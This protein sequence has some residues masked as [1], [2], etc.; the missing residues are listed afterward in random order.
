MFEDVLVVAV[1][2]AFYDCSAV[3]L[4]APSAPCTA[5][6]SSPWGCH[7]CPRSH[8]CITGG[9]CPTGEVTIY[10]QNASVGG[11]RGSQVCPRLGAVKGS[12]LVP[13]GVEVTLDLEAHN[14]NLLGVPLPRL[15]CVLEVGRGLVEVEASPGGPYRLQCGPHAYDFGASAPQ[16]RAPVYVTV[17]ERWHLD[18]PSGLHVMLTTA[19]APRGVPHL[20]ALPPLYI[21]IVCQVPPAEGG[22]S[23]PVEVAVGDQ[24]PGVSIQHFT[25]QDPQLWELH[26]RIGPVAGGTQVTVTGEELATGPDVAVFLGDL[27]CS[28]VEPPAPGTLVCLTTGGTL[29][30]APLRVQFGK[31]LRHLTGGGGFHYAPNPNITWAWPRSSFCGGGRIIQA[32]V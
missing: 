15:R 11:P 29:G 16:L 31:V 17:G 3:A 8:C 28:L 19:S 4:L 1:G 14:L 9:S 13:V 12:P 18:T 24:P 25:Y 20:P 32:A 5:C 27:P 23:G 22:V 21:R 10:N 6:V 30:E 26:P 2:F 7:W